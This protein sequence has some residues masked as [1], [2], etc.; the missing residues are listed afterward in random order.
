M[1]L[2]VDACSATK[3]GVHSEE[4]DSAVCRFR[5][6]RLSPLSPFSGSQ[7][8]QEILK[9]SDLVTKADFRVLQFVYASG[10]PCH[11]DKY[12]RA[13][14]P[15]KAAYKFN[16]Q[17]WKKLANTLRSKMGSLPLTSDSNAFLWQ[18]TANSVD[19][20]VADESL[21]AHSLKRI[22]TIA[23]N[24]N[25]GILSFGPGDKHITKTKESIE[26]KIERSLRDGM[27]SQETAIHFIDDGVRGTIYCKTPKALG[28][29]VKTFMKK[30]REAQIAF[31]PTDLWKV[32][33]DC[34]GYADIEMKIK[35]PVEPKADG[36]PVK[37]VLGEIQFHLEDFYDAT[38]DSAVA[39]AHKIYE[40][41]RMTPV[42]ML[43][44]E[45]PVSYEEMTECSRLY[46]CGAMLNSLKLS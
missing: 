18:N 1:T 45:I 37:Y 13:I 4:N 26:S 27:P 30:A 23:T 8:I 6:Q 24:L 22:M 41:L 33:Y 14:V 3:I 38:S 12:L 35:I 7:R 11:Y 31:S 43:S 46:F 20:L 10:T 40:N 21:A 25:G 28:K 15:D 17:I 39:R 29:S 16:Q 42:G 44:K 9:I 5:G 36:S 19:E 2:S 34:A 32:S